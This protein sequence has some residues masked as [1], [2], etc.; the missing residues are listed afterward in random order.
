MIVDPR[1]A[2]CPTCGFGAGI[3]LDD[4]ENR[5]PSSLVRC[6]GCALDATGAD[7]FAA[8]A[9]ERRVGPEDR[10]HTVRSDR[11]HK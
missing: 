2:R 6:L 11:R 3:Y 1:P 9:V 4:K 7:W 5:T 10:R 8:G